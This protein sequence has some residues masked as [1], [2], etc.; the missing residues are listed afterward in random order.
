VEVT[1]PGTGV[2]I[3][4]LGIEVLERGGP[5]LLDPE[6]HRVGQEFLEHLGGLHHV[7]ETVRLHTLE[8][9]FETKQPLEHP[10]TLSPSRK[11]KGLADSK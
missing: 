5:L 2:P 4:R 6:G 10:R 11:V 1:V 9:L 8:K 3:R 7:L